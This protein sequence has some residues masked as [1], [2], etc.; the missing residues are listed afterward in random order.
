M[1]KYCTRLGF[2]SMFANMAKKNTINN[3]KNPTGIKSNLTLNYTLVVD[4]NLQ[5]KC[6][7]HR[8][9]FSLFN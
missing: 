1:S 4:L 9:C 5:E 8:I 2:M 3:K 7:S 6:M